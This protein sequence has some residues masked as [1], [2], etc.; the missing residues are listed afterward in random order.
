MEL[1]K[2]ENRFE[3]LF[4]I[5]RRL[6]EKRDMYIGM[7]GCLKQDNS[8][9]SLTL[10]NTLDNTQESINFYNKIK[11]YIQDKKYNEIFKFFNGEKK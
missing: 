11:E 1:D 7:E 10:E 5:T 6:D 3:T 2:M 4:C 8:K 9:V